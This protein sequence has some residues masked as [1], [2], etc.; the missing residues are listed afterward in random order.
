MP[1]QLPGVLKVALKLK[2]WTGSSCLTCR[3]ISFKMCNWEQVNK[4]LWCR[5]LECLAQ[6]SLIILRAVFENK[7]VMQHLTGEL[8]K[9]FASL[10]FLFFPSDNKI[11]MKRWLVAGL[12]CVGFSYCCF[13]FCWGHIPFT[14]KYTSFYKVPSQIRMVRLVWY[15]WNNLKCNITFMLIKSQVIR[16]GKILQIL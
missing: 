10:H 12:W 4:Y 2:N 3:D 13:F 9:W 15:G 7:A 5:S 1:L 8:E 16:V 6:N 14:E 11:L